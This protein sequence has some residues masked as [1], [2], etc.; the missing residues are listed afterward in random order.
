MRLK[1]VHSGHALPDKL[2][3]SFMNIVAGHAPGVV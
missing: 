1:R 3:L 2:F